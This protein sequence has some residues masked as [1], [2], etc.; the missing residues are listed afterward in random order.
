M[1]YQRNFNRRVLNSKNINNLALVICFFFTFSITVAQQTLEIKKFDLKGPQTD[2]EEQKLK[3]EYAPLYWQSIFGLPNDPHKSLIA[4]DGSLMYNFDGYLYDFKIQEPDYKLRFRPVLDGMDEYTPMHQET[5]DA[6]IPIFITEAL[7]DDLLMRQTTWAMAPSAKEV[8]DWSV[9]RKDFNEISIMN[10]ATVKKTSNFYLE[11]HTP[12]ELLLTEHHLVAKDD[13]KK[14]Y[15]SFHEA[16]RELIAIPGGYQLLFNP[17][18]IAPNASHTYYMVL[19]TAKFDEPFNHDPDLLQS[20]KSLHSRA[21]ALDDVKIPT[22]KLFRDQMAKAI[23]YWT[24]EANIPYEKIQVP[25]PTLQNLLD[26]CIR[27]IYQASE[28]KND[29]FMIQIGPGHYRGTWAADGPFFTE[30]LVYLG[31]NEDARMAIEN[32]FDNDETDPAGLTFYK[33][34]GLRLWMIL[35]HVELT[36]DTNWLAS[37]WPKVIN[38]VDLIKKYRQMSYEDQS[39]INDGLMPA[40]A[41][42]GGLGGRDVGTRQSEGMSNFYEYTNVYWNLVGLKAAITLSKLFEPS[43]TKGWQ[44][45]Y[46]DFYK[47]FQQAA[48]RDSMVDA[49]G[50]SYVPVTM[51]GDVPQLP[52]RGAWAFMHSV[53]PGKVYEKNDPLL[54]GMMNMLDSAQREGTVYGTGW[55]AHGIWSYFAS[56]YAHAHLWQGHGNKAAATLYAFANHAAPTGVWVEEQYP[57]GQMRGEDDWGDMPHNWASAEFIRLVRHLLILE[58]DNELHLLEGMP[59]TWTLPGAETRVDNVA[60]SFGPI[61]LEVKVAADNKTAWI[62]INPP[63]RDISAKLVLHLE[64][65]NLPVW[66]VE[67]GNRFFKPNQSIL[68]DTNNNVQIKIYFKHLVESRYKSSY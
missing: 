46:D 59:S 40:G 17:Q 45:E 60:T 34:S 35:R 29:K 16:P 28:Y 43:K 20:Y 65:F 38:D 33:R 15:A 21:I 4:S 2:L 6:K 63:K 48:K 64:Q 23:T 61:S 1:T 52:Q 57:V 5:M 27:N 42:D 26:A 49:F 51:K 66:K 25:D 36:G 13:P 39:P 41:G 55:L 14:Y 56:F 67:V 54:L 30:S 62:N 37:V 12:D 31:K 11:I 7:H 53:Y 47:A 10:M 9:Q 44:A 22:E 18:D 58:R 24:V 19:H 8:E 50:N 32:L 3:Y 68:L